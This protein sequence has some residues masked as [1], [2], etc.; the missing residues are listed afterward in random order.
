MSWKSQIWKQNLIHMMKDK[1][2]LKSRQNLD[3]VKKL[4]C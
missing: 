4:M 3:A 1:R 2:I